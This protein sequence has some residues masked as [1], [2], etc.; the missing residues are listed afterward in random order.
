MYRTELNN[1]IYVSGKMNRI[2]AYEIKNSAFSYLFSD[3]QRKNN[4]AEV[5]VVNRD[6]NEVM[7]SV[8]IMDERLNK[9]S[10]LG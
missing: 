5:I 3:K 4:D 8:A 7:F 9:W 1:V 10:L 2:Y 6:K